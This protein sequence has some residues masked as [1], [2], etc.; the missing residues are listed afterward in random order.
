[1]R[2]TL[3]VSGMSCTSGKSHRGRMGHGKCERYAQELVGQGNTRLRHMATHVV[4]E[5]TQLGLS[6]LLTNVCSMP[7]GCI[8]SAS[9][10]Q[11]STMRAQLSLAC[12]L[13][14]VVAAFAAASDSFRAA[15]VQYVPVDATGAARWIVF[16]ASA[17]AHLPSVR[18]NPTRDDDAEYGKLPYSHTASCQEWGANCRVPRVWT[19][20][21][22]RHVQ[23]LN[24]V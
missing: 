19:A 6:P 11:H 21:C 16:G 10:A 23:V 14:C 7:C 18:R 13:G 17:R 22:R 12:I 20:R 3:S 1:M 8:R 24:S 9:R 4:S 5:G 2:S 15:T